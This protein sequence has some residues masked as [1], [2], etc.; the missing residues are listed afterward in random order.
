[1]RKIQRKIYRTYADLVLKKYPIFFKYDWFTESHYLRLNKNKFLQDTQIKDFV[2][3]IMIF[4]KENSINYKLVSNLDKLEK[5]NNNYLEFYTKLYSSLKT[6]DE[7]RVFL[8]NEISKINEESPRRLIPFFNDLSENIIFP[9]ECKELAKAEEEPIQIN[10]SKIDDYL[11][12][13]KEHKEFFIRVCEEFNPKILKK[14]KYIIGSQEYYLIVAICK[15]SDDGL[16]QQLIKA[17][18]K[19]LHQY[20]Q[21]HFDWKSKTNYLGILM[22]KHTYHKQNVGKEDYNTNQGFSKRQQQIFEKIDFKYSQ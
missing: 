7:L 20:L 9:F 19:V 13:F 6:E 14:G 22:N 17:K 15:A 5:T 2:S 1:M 11:F 10:L 18:Y 21:N 4:A 12:E 8:H 3:R 16:I